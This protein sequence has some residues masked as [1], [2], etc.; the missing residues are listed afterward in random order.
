MK[1]RYKSWIQEIKDEW[2]VNSK[3][4]DEQYKNFDIN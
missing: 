1:R 4:E 3:D 2:L